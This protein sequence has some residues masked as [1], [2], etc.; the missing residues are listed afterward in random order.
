MSNSNN[1][2]TLDFSH[3]VLNLSLALRNFL[4][5]KVASFPQAIDVRPCHVKFIVESLIVVVVVVVTSY[6]LDK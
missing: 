5:L 4:F 6:N 2:W 3:R 1:V